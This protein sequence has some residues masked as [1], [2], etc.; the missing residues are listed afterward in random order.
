M[1]GDWF[2]VFIFTLTGVSFIVP[3][4]KILLSFF[5][6]SLSL[7]ISS[8]GFAADTEAEEAFNK[9]EIEYNQGNYRDAAK[10][11]GDA[12]LLADSYMLKVNSLKSQ[13][14]SY[15][16]ANML[17]QE[18]LALK[19]LTEEYPDQTFFSYAILREYHIGNSFYEG[20]REQ[21]WA[22]VPW[23]EDDDKSTEIYA[24]I[25]KQSP[26]ASFI[27][28]MMLKMGTRYVVNKKPDKAIDIYKKMILQYRSSPLT[29]F[30]YLDLANIYLQLAAS[31]DGD[32]SKLREARINLKDYV[33]KYPAS[34]EIKWAKNMLKK[35]YEMEAMRLY[36]L[37]NYY[38]KAGND[39][40]S[41]RYIKE[42][43]V[44]YPDTKAVNK[45]DELLDIIEMPLY[46]KEKPP[47]PEEPTK[48][49][50]RGMRNTDDRILVIPVNS[51]NKWLVPLKET[52]IG[53]DNLTKEKYINNL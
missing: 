25:L 21:P 2:F 6:I 47:L 33:D 36:R 7:C 1:C 52:G 44:N 48:Y 49:T 29:R 12:Q 24:S 17:Y 26:F 11:F 31:G 20:Y 3:Y 53:N 42:I 4:R 50:T 13:A 10:G 19:K 38:Y 30:A 22:W 28:E 5:A 18:F 15:R 45:A 43:L 27:P 39:N 40:A 51:G 8:S 46:P 35:T 9:A 41:K 32:G 23:I 14:I 37:A 16:K 34:P